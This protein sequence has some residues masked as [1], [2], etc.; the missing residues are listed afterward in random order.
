VFAEVQQ[1]ARRLLRGE[2]CEV[3]SILNGSPGYR[4]Q[5]GRAA[6]RADRRKL[7][8]RALEIGKAVTQPDESRLSAAASSLCAPIFVRG[9]AVACLFVT[10]ENIRGLFGADEECLADFITAL[11]G[12]ALENADGFARL[13]QL[14]STLE[15]R[16]AERTA[17]AET[18]ATELALSNSELERIA[19]ELRLTEEELRAAKE[20]AENASRAKTQFLATMSHEIRTPMNGIIGMTNLALM[21]RVTSQQKSYLT[22]ARQSADSL[23]RLLN[24]ILD[25]SKVEAGKMELEEVPFDLHETVADAVRILSVR[26]SQCGLELNYLIDRDV[27]ARVCGDAGRLRQVIVNLVGNAIK[28]TSEGEVEIGVRVAALGE[29][30][31]RLHFA[32][33]DTGIGISPE[34][35]Q[36]IFD[37]FSQADSSITRRFGGTGL[38]LSISSELVRLMQGQLQVDSRLDKGST[39]HFTARF[40]LPVGMEADSIPSRLPPLQVLVVDDHPTSRHV[41][42]ETLDQLGLQPQAVHDAGSA[43]LMLRYAAAAG[44]P[45]KVA[46][47][48]AEMPGQDGW[49]LVDEIR[50]DPELRDCPVV[51]LVPADVL[52]AERRSDEPIPN[53][54]YFTKPAKA[55]ELTSAIQEALGLGS[56]LDGESGDQLLCRLPSMR[57][58][59]ADDAPV[60]QEVGKGLLE[61]SGHHVEIANNG[62]EALD[63]LE[64]AEFDVVLMDLEMPKMDGASATIAIRER[65]Q[66]TGKRI[67]I[68]A[69]TAHA[70]AEIRDRCLSVG[71]DGYLTKPI[72]L[73]K[74]SRALEAIHSGQAALAEALA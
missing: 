8:E 25:L 26:S 62:L 22:V 24:D 45:F 49:S 18:R 43:L 42:E 52:Q 3:I 27:P 7:I 53:T 17:A 6:D 10:H 56:T 59:L 73:E 31:V 72:Q 63:L 66:G 2:S 46:V 9:A 15:Q 58:L 38:G 71:M 34:Q 14:N 55:S 74:L 29:G 60:N 68:L 57:I 37:S 30:E 12:A 39:F 50:R 11:A 20:I 47:I 4:E 44:V 36:R 41:L 64:A 61:M 51:L 54:W 5:K 13:Q 1:A 67:P 32:I 69:M 70:T 65:E 28:F 16:V 48:D 35:Q 19:A 33:R 23:L 40:T 21:T